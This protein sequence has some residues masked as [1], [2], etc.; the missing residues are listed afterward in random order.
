[1]LSTGRRKR[2][3]ACGFAD[4]TLLAR[5]C[6]HPPHDQTIRVAP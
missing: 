3:A 6:K 1:L 2:G 5:E 4:A